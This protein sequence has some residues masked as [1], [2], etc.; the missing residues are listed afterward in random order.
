MI[1]WGAE[2]MPNIVVNNA[3]LHFTR[4]GVGPETIVFSHGLLFSGAMFE[5][6]VEHFQD[7]YH[8]VTYDH[9]GQGGSEVTDDGY[10]MDTLT[11]DAIALIEELGVG[12]CHFAGLSMGGFIGLRI[13]IRRPDLLRSLIL[14]ESTADPEPPE[15]VPKYR[16]LNKV[17]RWFGLGMVIKKVMPI[18]FSQSFLNSLSREDEHNLWRDRIV[19]NDRVGITRA[20]AGVIDRQGVSDQLGK[21]DT[22]TLIIVGEEDVAT[23]PEMSE[24]MHAAIRGSKLVRIRRAGH[25]STIEEPAAVNAAIEDF[26]SGLS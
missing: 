4:E 20:V 11:D 10:D 26:L 16:K 9:R 2:T 8:C 13:A 15:N 5:S 1:P 17:A 19:A 6:Q 22:P 12:P 14:I 7:R 3:S 21:I 18:M 23:V 24:R 25:S